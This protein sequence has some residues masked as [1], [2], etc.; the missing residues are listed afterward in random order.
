MADEKIVT[1][2]TAA[3]PAA[4]TKQVTA[5][6]PAP[7]ATKKAVV[8]P[9][10]P[11]PEPA[12]PPM[13]K[14][15]AAAAAAKTSRPAAAKAAE[16]AA[17]KAAEPAAPQ[18]PAKKTAAKAAVSPKAKESKP[19]APLEDKPV[20]LQHLK[21][22]TPEQRQDMIREAAYYRAERR[23]FT[24]GSD[25]EDWAAAEREIDELMARAKEIFG[26]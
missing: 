15:A 24:N 25:A 9:K 10:S 23:N 18:P 16:P 1:K 19:Q 7:S 4:P 2:K 5:D 3:K 22:V 14:A 20:S 12:A 11:P 17:P 6:A 13:T 8:K 26:A 21:N